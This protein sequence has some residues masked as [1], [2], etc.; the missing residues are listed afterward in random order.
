MTKNDKA[1]LFS[2]N[3]INPRWRAI[4][5]TQ[6]GSRVAARRHIGGA[7]SDNPETTMKADSLVLALGTTFLVTTLAAGTAD[8]ASR[9]VVRPN[10]EGGTTATAITAHAGPNGG[11]SVR[12]RGVAT[13]GQG[14]A[15]TV[16]GGA[17]KGPN[18]A[19][20]ARAGTT[21]RSADGSMTHWSGMTAQG[22]KG[23]I[24][25]SGSATRNASGDVTQSRSSTATSAATG[26]TL[27]TSES[28]S[29]GSG[30]TR[31]AACFDASGNSIACP[32]H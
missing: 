31:S 15:K 27:K 5:G 6:P 23:S 3:V 8:A 4:S 2:S 13:D 1:A 32:K 12:G 14:D 16:S 18:G 21:S 19:T 29:S 26:D 28:Y 22:A 30:V 11:K 17:F 20:G 24:Q 10:A 7:T 25:S 9:R